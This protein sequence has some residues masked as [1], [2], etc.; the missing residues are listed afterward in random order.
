MG[1]VAASFK[2]LRRG[3]ISEYTQ[4]LEDSR[5]HAIDRMVRQ[6]PAARRRRDRRGPLR[7][8]GD[9]TA[10]H[11]DRRLRDGGQGRSRRPRPVGEHAAGRRGAGAA[12]RD[13]H[14]PRRRGTPRRGRARAPRGAGGRGRHPRGGRRGGGG[15]AAARWRRPTRIA[16]LAADAATARSTSPARTGG[17]PASGSAT[18]A[19]A[20]CCGCGS[21]PAG[22]RHYV[23]E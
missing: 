9:R 6:R 11:R 7:L 1:G 15:P 3:E 23:A 8:L 17:P 22:D 21:T 2:A 20:G 12:L 13:A 14:A 19:P 10:V 5:R 16:G 18:R 4:L